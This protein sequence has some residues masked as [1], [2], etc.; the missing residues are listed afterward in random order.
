MRPWFW[1]AGG[2]VALVVA[3]VVTV[4]LLRAGSDTSASVVTVVSGDDSFSCPTE[5]G[6]VAVPL[7]SVDQL[8]AGVDVEFPAVDLAGALGAVPE[9]Y[10]FGEPLEHV[11]AAIMCSIGPGDINPPG[12]SGVQGLRS[13]AQGTSGDKP[14][15]TY[16]PESHSWELKTSSQSSAASSDPDAQRARVGFDLQI[17][18]SAPQ[19]WDEEG[20]MTAQTAVT[21]EVTRVAADGSSD[22]VEIGLEMTI[23]FSNRTK[24]WE[25]QVDGHTISSRDGV[26]TVDPSLSVLFY[27]D[28]DF[29]TVHAATDVLEAVGEI[30]G[31]ATSFSALEKAYEGNT[32]ER[33]SD[34]LE[35]EL[36]PEELSLESGESA[37]ISATV[38]DWQ[39]RPLVVVVSAEA[40]QGTFAP[41]FGP[42]GAADGLWATTYTAPDGDYETDRIVITAQRQA[43]V[44]KAR[45]TVRAPGQLWSLAM[46]LDVEE[47]TF[48][49]DGVFSV[50]GGKIEGDGI[51]TLLGSG[52]CVEN[53]V[54]VEVV[55]VTGMFTFEVSGT[56]ALRDGAE[57]L[58]LR[59]DATEAGVQLGSEDPRC[60]GFAEIAGTFLSLVPTFPAQYY[61]QGFD[62][63][64]TD[65]IGFSDLAM[66]PYILEV[67]VA[68]LGV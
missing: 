68:R 2:S 54:T 66:D 39:D 11:A 14:T 37:P 31:V 19:C 67:D 58:T 32:L 45:M 27:D 44:A 22:T 17:S 38:R 8:A 15:A 59:V 25:M 5:G 50:S 62:I 21:G 30:A 9:E 16:D 61:P 34:C 65:G 43:H 40:A 53:G 60:V 49:W 57:W 42:S 63:Q 36:S 6:F 52:E 18:A 55:E 7:P 24:D 48:L 10:L 51:G 13:F 12:E 29:A 46:T 23:N 28:D 64:V 35:V 1:W 3:G 56:Q 41:G 47:V 20:N 4:G 26:E 33:I